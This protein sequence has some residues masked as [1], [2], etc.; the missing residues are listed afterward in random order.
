MPNVYIYLREVYC[1]KI[2]YNCNKI[3]MQHLV[4]FESRDTYARL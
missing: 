3:V 4:I 1:N 2:L